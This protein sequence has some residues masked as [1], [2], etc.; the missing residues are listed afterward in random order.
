MDHGPQQA[1]EGS[2]D[3]T[4]LILRSPHRACV[5]NRLTRTGTHA[6]IPAALHRERADAAGSPFS[7]RRQ[8]RGWRK[9]LVGVEQAFTARLVQPDPEALAHRV[10]ELF[11]PHLGRRMRCSERSGG[12]SDDRVVVHNDSC[13]HP[14]RCN[15]EYF[16]RRARRRIRLDLPSSLL[17]G[18][19]PGWRLRCY[20]ART[21]SKDARWL[22][23]Y[24]ASG[25]PLPRQTTTHV[26][27]AL[28]RRVAFG[29]R[30][31]SCLSS[32]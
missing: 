7:V 28:R 21:R 5:R 8:L 1:G 9:P 22:L 11:V 26:F 13:N 18:A 19:W 25:R 30:G 31:V 27:R 24:P 14:H 3:H 16:F 6:G 20:S 17:Q 32:P 10:R 23:N 12:G 4:Q 15:V 29:R 2:R